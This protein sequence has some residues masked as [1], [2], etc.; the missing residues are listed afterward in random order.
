MA[1]CNNCG[2]LTTFNE[3]SSDGRIANTLCA[4][5][6]AMTASGFVQDK[7]NYFK[8]DRFDA[9]YQLNLAD[10]EIAQTNARIKKLR[11]ILSKACKG[12]KVLYQTVNILFNHAEIIDLFSI[13]VEA[14]MATSEAIGDVA[15]REHFTKF[16]DS[17][18]DREMRDVS[19]TIEILNEILSVLNYAFEH[20]KNLKIYGD[21]SEFSPQYGKFR[22]V[23]KTAK[24]ELLP[25]FDEKNKY[26]KS[27]LQ[28]V[29]YII[30]WTGQT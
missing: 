22:S 12:D 13:E 11:R 14:C 10:I 16:L 9:S 30:D 28:R 3:G 21:L 25:F 17:F 27:T 15:I 29:S 7:F 18:R 26:I 24:K 20:I 4:A 1:K 2:I 5:C 23:Y 19:Q 6:F 8:R